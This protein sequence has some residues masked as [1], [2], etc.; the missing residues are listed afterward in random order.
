MTNDDGSP[1]ELMTKNAGVIPSEVEE[2]RGDTFRLPS[3]DSFDFAQDDAFPFEY[4][5]FVIPSSLGH[6]S[7]V[8]LS[9]TDFW[10]YR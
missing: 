9:V 3:R 1:N 10:N 2:S 7:F 6:S 8:I 5:G 4:S